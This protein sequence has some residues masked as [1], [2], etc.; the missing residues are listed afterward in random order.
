MSRRA[1]RPD[2]VNQLPV[3]F[4]FPDSLNIDGGPAALELSEKVL[5]MASPEFLIHRQHC[6]N[7]M[8]AT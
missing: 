4:Y 7:G 3:D 1:Q 5:M 8:A 6:S 2:L